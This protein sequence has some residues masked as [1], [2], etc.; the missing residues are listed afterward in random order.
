MVDIIIIA[1]VALIV[2]LAGGYVYRK[3]KRGVRCIGCPDGGACRHSCG[4]CSCG[5]CK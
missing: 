5:C 4:T 3:K 2:G 1:L